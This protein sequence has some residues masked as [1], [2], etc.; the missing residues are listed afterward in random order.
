MVRVPSTRSVWYTDHHR[1][2]YLG[3][4]PG[5]IHNPFTFNGPG[6]A[7]V[8]VCTIAHEKY[9]AFNLYEGHAPRQYRVIH[10]IRI[11]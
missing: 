9:V 10:S 1:Y 7:R 3:L 11:R 8:Y 4:P 6:I 5:E 2:F